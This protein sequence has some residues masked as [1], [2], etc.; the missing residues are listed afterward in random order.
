MNNTTNDTIIELLQRHNNADQLLIPEEELWV[1]DA[2]VWPEPEPEPV[3][4]PG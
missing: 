3:P 4:E 2:P 1:V